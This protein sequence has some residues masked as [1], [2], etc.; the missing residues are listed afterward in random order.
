MFQRINF[1]WKFLSG[2]FMVISFFFLFHP[3]AFSQEY[4]MEEECPYL[5]A[6]EYSLKIIDFSTGNGGG[7]V[8][9]T[10]ESLVTPENKQG[11]IL[12]EDKVSSAK[13]NMEVTISVPQDARSVVLRL[14]G[15]DIGGWHLQSTHL[16]CYDHYLLVL[17]FFLLAVFVWFY[18]DRYYCKD[19]NYILC[20]IGA[21][22]LASL[23]NFGN[24]LIRTGDLL[25]HLARINGIYE[26]MRT[27]QF[28]VIINPVQMGGIGSASGAMY[29]QLFLYIPA[30][31]K[32]LNISSFLGIKF[33]YIG[34]NL[35]T[36]FFTYYAVRRL[37]SS[38]RIALMAAVMF[39]LN[40]YR[41]IDLYSR[42]ALGEFLALAFLP[43]VLWGT[44]E[45][46]WGRKE[47]WWILVLGMTGVLGSHILSLEIDAV[48]IFFEIVLWMFSQKKDQFWKRMLALGKATFSTIVLNLYFIGPFLSFMK[49]GLL[50]FEMNVAADEGTVDLIRA[51][52]PLSHWSDLYFSW[53]TRGSMSVTIGSVSLAGIIMFLAFVLQ[54]GKQ[55]SQTAVIELGKRYLILGS[56]FL[57]AATWVTPWESLMRTPLLE[58]IQVIEFPW[59]LLGFSALLFSIVAAIAVEQWEKVWKKSIPLWIFMLCGLLFEC[60]SY[61]ENMSYSAPTID[62]YGAEG[63]DYYDEVYIVADRPSF[64]VDARFSHIMCDEEEHLNWVMNVYNGSDAECM[65]PENI[66][67]SNY[68]RDGLNI[69]ADV[70]VK[71]SA[72]GNIEASFP[73]YHYSGYSVWIDGEKTENYPRWSLVTCEITPGEHHIEVSYTGFPFFRICGVIT[74]CSVVLPALW[75]GIHYFKR[76][77]KV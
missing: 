4:T 55:E 41:L 29:P 36:A 1:V 42:N 13:G 27:G 7:T 24:Y 48:L 51:F 6:G 58:R 20:L 47:K 15:G 70:F 26:G 28:P 12:F 38:N 18:G 67:W 23:P 17:L 5:P 25:F 76:K 57:L 49:E 37:C 72:G 31:L 59:R 77:R 62:I 33:L 32:F 65:E 46:L 53:G 61:Y 2:L 34:A 74:L 19:H 45:I 73:L 14:D 8:T 10:A 35:A 63:S 68:R 66:V 22:L 3:Q 30:L 69:S 16:M 52:A 75:Q 43:L 71:E 56:I 44:Y 9:L 50:C 64:P 21:A 60:G 40:P 54:K 39:T 11:V